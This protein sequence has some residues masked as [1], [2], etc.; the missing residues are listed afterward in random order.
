MGARPQKSGA[1]TVL[2]MSQV[3]VPDPTSVGQH[4]H[5]VAKE[6]ARRGCRVRV[7]TA[8]RG[9]EDT[10]VTYPARE[11]IC[12]VDVRRL[13]LS[14][15]GK[16]SIAIRLAAGLS[17]TTQCVVRGLFMRNLTHIVVSTS[18]P[19]CSLAAVAISLFRRVRITYW[20]MDLNPDQMIEMGNAS[21]SSWQVRIFD[22]LN[23]QI[24]RRA[25]A[26]VALDRFMA[27][28]LLRKADV[29]GKL[30][31]LPPWPLDDYVGPVEH[32][33][34]PFREA[35]GLV[36]K[37]VIMY[38]GNLSIVSPID[39]ILAVARRV[40]DLADLVFLFVGGGLGKK[41]VDELIVRERPPNIRTLPYQPIENLRY[42]LSAG[43]VHLVSVGEKIVGISH[44]CKI[45][46]SM[47]VGRPV[48]S[49]GPAES[50]A[51]D[52]LS[53]ANIGWAIRH[54]DIEQAERTI[55]HVYSMGRAQRMAMG[56]TAQKLVGDKYSKQLLLRRF[57]N[58]VEFGPGAADGA[59]AGFSGG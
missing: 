54:G 48:L 40:T 11:V 6:F 23:R 30:V 39:T 9:Y 8:A 44:P 57:A 28:R 55:R 35:H 37:V 21:A 13:P 52:I 42:S 49:L 18:P 33:Q 27:A 58:I 19:M 51:S 29:T 1:T 31:V 7:L 4:M 34:N 46:G 5:D 14:S 47:A 45:Y 22:W 56:A 53:E 20:V 25:S 41:V 10:S 50:H 24:L 15:F 59:R 38:S 2:V 43:D 3:Y 12:G 32:E 16:S 36:G 17:F 26:V